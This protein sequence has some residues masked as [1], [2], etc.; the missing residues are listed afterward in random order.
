MTKHYLVSINI[1]SMNFKLF[2]EFLLIFSFLFFDSVFEITHARFF[3]PLFY[4][5]AFW[6]L[7]SHYNE[8]HDL[9]TNAYKMLSDVN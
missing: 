6:K 2:T 5:N 1:T 9:A 4:I 3:Q 7:S 8:I